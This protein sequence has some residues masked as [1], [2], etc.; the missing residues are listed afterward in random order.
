MSYLKRDMTLRA[1]SKMQYFENSLLELH[2]QHNIPFREDLGRRNAL[3]S[4]AQ[5]VFFAQELAP[6]HSVSTSGKTGEADI[7]IADINRELE[8]KLTSGSGGSWSLQTDYSTLCKKGSLDYLYVLAD[9]EFKSFAVLYFEALTPDQFHTPS[10][11][12]REKSRM[13]KSAA[14]DMCEV[15]VGSVTLRNDQMVD[16]YTEMSRNTLRSIVDRDFET[17]RRIEETTAPKRLEQLTTMRERELEIG[18]RKIQ[19]LT[20][21]ISH[22]FVAEQQYTIE[23]ETI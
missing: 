7:I 1:L 3:L 18:L 12:A 17:A 10:P 15:L 19:R 23:L 16:K 21:K 14:M 2:R 9:P 6:S 4:R 8:C 22:W 5:E 13:N 20:D 11:G